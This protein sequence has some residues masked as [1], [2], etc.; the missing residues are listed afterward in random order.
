QP[1][2]IPPRSSPICHQTNSVT[3][4]NFNS[5]AAS[6]K[7]INQMIYRSPIITSTSKRNNII[8]SQILERQFNSLA[9]NNHNQ[10]TIREYSLDHLINYIV[11]IIFFFFIELINL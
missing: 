10:E 1:P 9:I 11:K 4:S 8:D 6:P 7:P 2:A 3:I 5:S